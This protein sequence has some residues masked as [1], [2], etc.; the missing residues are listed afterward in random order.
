MN[1]YFLYLVSISI[2]ICH[3][4]IVD[5]YISNDCHFIGVLLFP[6]GPYMTYMKQPFPAAPHKIGLVGPT[7]Q[8][9]LVTMF[10]LDITPIL[11]LVKLD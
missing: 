10:H 4:N 5:R 1:S 9:P 2:S 7:N 8:L 6:N 11:H 3:Y